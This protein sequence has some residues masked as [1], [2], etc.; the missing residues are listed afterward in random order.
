MKTERKRQ[1]EK[2]MLQSMVNI[3]CKGRHHT[4]KGSLCPRMLFYHP[5]AALRHIVVTLKNRK[6]RKAGKING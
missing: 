3:Y 4:K 6:G 2:E 5:P 1:Q